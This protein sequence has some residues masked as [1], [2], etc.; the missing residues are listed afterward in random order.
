MVD[1]YYQGKTGILPKDDMET[2]INPHHPESTLAPEPFVQ[3]MLQVIRQYGMAKR[4]MVQ[5]FDWRTLE[6]LHQQRTAEQ[7]VLG[8]T[9]QLHGI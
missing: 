4:V 8:T 6:L 1:A 7:T 2:K 3:T 5:S 9:N